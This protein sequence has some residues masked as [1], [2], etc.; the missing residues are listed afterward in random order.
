M[1]STGTKPGGTKTG[2]KT[3][4]TPNKVSS[5]AS[6]KLRDMELTADVAVEA[7]RR[8]LTADLGDCFDA[9]GNLRPLH[10]LTEAQ[11]W[12]ISGI[13]VIRKNAEGG[14]GHTDIIHKIKWA[15]R[16]KYAELA[17]RYH[18]L[19]TDRTEFTV[20][21]KAMELLLN[22]RKRAAALRVGEGSTLPKLLD[23]GK[24]EPAE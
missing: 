17:A 23:P 24:K 2:G 15:N 14:D 1:S 20:D 21:E 12:N 10:E 19:L 8:G 11:R 16:E 6:K 18:A 13:E 4:G 7:I 3:K 9:K 5:M 22:G